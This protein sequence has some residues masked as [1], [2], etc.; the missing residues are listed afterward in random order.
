M[1]TLPIFG[2]SFA[3]F[4]PVASF[5]F[6][7]FIKRAVRYTHPTL[8]P[9]HATDSSSSLRTRIK[10]VLWSSRNNMSITDTRGPSS[11][12]GQAIIYPMYQLIYILHAQNYT[13]N[14][15][16]LETLA[17]VRRVLQCHGSFATA[18]CLLCR[19][20]VP[21]SEIEA[22]ILNRK[23]SLC[24]VC[25]P[26]QAAPPRKKK[27]GR[28]KAKGGWDSNDEDASDGPDYPPGIMKV[29]RA[30]LILIFVDAN[31]IY[32]SQI[33][34]SSVR[35]SRMTSTTPSQKIERKSTCF[36]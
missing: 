29:G 16:T 30:G 20:R 6:L 18:S 34:H 27:Q 4:F 15:D 13:Q 14:I 23:V 35:N 21:G 8:Y 33:S 2:S 12:Y 25:N 28:K 17:G 22:D 5:L 9:L 19:R 26:P 3:R 31:T 24:T 1:M 7:L 11:F 10:Y 32:P 36:W